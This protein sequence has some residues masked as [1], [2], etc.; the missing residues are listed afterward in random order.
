MRICVIGDC[1]SVHVQDRIAPFLAKGHHIHAIT[2]R[3]GTLAGLVESVPNTRRL[4][5]G[6]LSPF[7]E[8]AAMLDHYRLI[9][10][11]QADVIHVHY[12]ASLGAWLLMV[13]ARPEPTIVSVM[14][15]DILD[16]EQTPLPALARW[17]T[18]QILR[19]AD[20]VTVK[21]EFLR[22]ILKGWGVLEERILKVMW[23]VDQS[24]FHPVGVEAV[25]EELGLG[26][27]HRVIF[28]PRILRPFYN[29]H[30]IIEGMPFILKHEPNARLILTEYE[31]EPPYRDHLRKLIDK[32]DVNRAV[33]WA[34]NVP[35][36]RMPE[37]FSLADV[38][39][40]VPPSDGFP[41][42][43]LEAL[44]CRAPCVVSRL[45]RYEEV[46]RDGENA[47]FTDLEA[48][49]IANAVLKALQDESAAQ[50]IRDGGFVAVREVSDFEGDIRRLGETYE[51]LFKQGSKG[52]VSVWIRI[53]CGMTL[54]GLTIRNTLRAMAGIICGR[55]RVSTVP[56]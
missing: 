26:L 51:R 27:N 55:H 21:T 28:S 15:G 22:E 56:E 45:A 25:R 43:I 32:L 31:A 8:A 42:S 10:N 6:W 30:R 46:I 18:K 35:H 47:F 16:E 9:R 4:G 39:V 17:M 2:P 3:R 40:S 48:P 1:H 11:C 52:P 53:F 7:N 36:A 20:C 24:T 49:D 41:Q 37:F 33:I 13:V 14:G 29:I 23:G 50:K 5:D 12:A 38:V 44:A 34:G 54:M 19:R